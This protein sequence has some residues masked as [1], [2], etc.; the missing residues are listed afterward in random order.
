MLIWPY[1]QSKYTISRDYYFKLNSC[2]LFLRVE[3]PSRGY[4]ICIQVI[5]PA[6]RGLELGSSLHHPHPL[7]GEFDSP[8]FA[9]LDKF[10]INF[11]LCFKMFTYLDS[12]E[13]DRRIQF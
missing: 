7:L 8:A 1:A 11:E 6:G 4:S 2:I 12:L 13:I 10:P 3:F 9:L 5:V